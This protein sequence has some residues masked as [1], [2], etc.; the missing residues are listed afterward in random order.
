M[1]VA[2]FYPVLSQLSN[3]RRTA[4]LTIIWINIF[5]KQLNNNF[6]ELCTI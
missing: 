5:F 6:Q 3:L 1:T 2:L 4:C